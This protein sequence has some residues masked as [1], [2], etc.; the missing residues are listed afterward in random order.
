[1]GNVTPAAT[2][3]VPSCKER[4]AP[5]ILG[6]LDQIAQHKALVRG[7]HT[8]REALFGLDRDSTGGIA[9]EQVLLIDQ[10]LT[11]LFDDRFDAR[12]VAHTVSLLLQCREVDFHDRSG[13]LLGAELFAVP[14]TGDHPCSKL[15][16]NSQVGIN[17]GL[18]FLQKTGLM[19]RTDPWRSLSLREGGESK[20]SIIG[21]R[22]TQKRE[23]IDQKS[24]VHATSFSNASTG[25]HATAFS[26]ASR[27][28]IAIPCR[29]IFRK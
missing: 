3:P 28:R 13:Q 6:L 21:R 4:F 2:S 25:F 23:Q 7:K 15:A 12:A 1:M 18:V 5:R 9:F 29:R 11:E 8:G 20:Q 22:R 14:W 26:C 10:P 19:I 24:G 16:E 27:G 17:S